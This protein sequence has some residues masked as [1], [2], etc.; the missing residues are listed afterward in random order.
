MRY[1]PLLGQYARKPK[2]WG[3]E[4]EEVWKVIH[5]CGNGTMTLQGDP[6]VAIIFLRVTHLLGKHVN[7]QGEMRQ[8]A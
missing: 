1:K 6:L 8:K 5:M 2:R 4:R 3:N 7:H